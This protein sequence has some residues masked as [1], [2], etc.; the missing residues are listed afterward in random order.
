M[1]QMWNSFCLHAMAF[2]MQSRQKSPSMLTA[3]ISACNPAILPDGSNIASAPEPKTDPPIC[4]KRY[5]DIQDFDKDLVHLVATH[6]RH[7][8]C[9][10]AYCLCTCNGRQQCHFGYPK[11]LQPQ[12]DI[13]MEEEPTILSGQ[14]DGMGNSFNPVQLS[15]WRANV[16]MY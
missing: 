13:V 9:S 1:H 7:T 4:N 16:D 2:L 11:P 6:Q 15:A 3:F 12:T 5:F 10:A 14:N 8:R